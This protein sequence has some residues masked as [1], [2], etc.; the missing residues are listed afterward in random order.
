M[1][2]VCTPS[3][4][5]KLIYPFK[6]DWLY[7]TETTDSRPYNFFRIRMLCI[8]APE[9]S[10]ERNKPYEYDDITDLECLEYWGNQ[11]K[12][13]ATN[14]PRGQENFENWEKRHRPQLAKISTAPDTKNLNN[15]THKWVICH[16]QKSTK[17]EG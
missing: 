3:I 13:F 5:L 9:T 17:G 8:D 16:S 14:I 6:I 15:F 7:E 10:D 12:V 11:A 2:I 1:K 4:Q